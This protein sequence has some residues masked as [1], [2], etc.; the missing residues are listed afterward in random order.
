MYVT[1][2]RLNIIAI[3]FFNFKRGKDTRLPRRS[4]EKAILESLKFSS[5]SNSVASYML[6]LTLSLRGQKLYMKVYIHC[7]FFC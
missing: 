2:L 5:C 7:Y 4:N 1:S 6:E 3:F